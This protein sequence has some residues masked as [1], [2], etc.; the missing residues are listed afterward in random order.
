MR[1][2]YR[3]KLVGKF[4]N[5]KY[6]KKLKSFAKQ[7]NISDNI[8]FIN[9][10]KSD[11]LNFI[12]RNASL[13]IF[14]S[15][16]ENCPNIL[17]ESLSFGL[18]TL[19]IN[20]PPMN[21]FGGDSVE[22]FEHDNIEDISKKIINILNSSKFREIL[23]KKAYLHSQNFNWDTFTKTILIKCRSNL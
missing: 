21:E 1:S 3:L 14:T 18:P 6:V 13:F 4:S 15:L 22:Y 20:L 8:D 7:L 19:V 11:E 5:K 10:L 23:S 17:L 9:E 12:Y 2:N 16:I